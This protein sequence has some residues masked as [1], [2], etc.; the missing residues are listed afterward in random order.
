MLRLRERYGDPEPER[1]PE[2]LLEIYLDP[3][4]IW[5][6]LRDLGAAPSLLMLLPRLP[7]RLLLPLPLKGLLLL[8]PLRLLS[9]SLSLFPSI[10]SR[11]RL[12][13]E[14]ISPVSSSICRL[15]IRG[16]IMSHTRSSVNRL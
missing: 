11:S 10:A 5:L 14:P 4:E 16:R 12:F 15:G 7:L 1:D 3:T 9:L 13:L 8:L 6:S 2:G